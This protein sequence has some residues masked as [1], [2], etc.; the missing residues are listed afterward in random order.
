M[1]FTCWETLPNSPPI[2][3]PL[4]FTTVLTYLLKEADFLKVTFDA[5]TYK[6]AV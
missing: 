4:L 6:C 5:A 2:K 1:H 3:R